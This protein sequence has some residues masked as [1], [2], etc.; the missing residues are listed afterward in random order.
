[1]RPENGVI[2]ESPETHNLVLH[3]ILYV[4]LPLWGFWGFVDWCCHRKT[5][6][7]STSGLHESLLHVTMGIQVGIPIIL[8]IVFEMNVLVM[9]CCF[10]S[11][12]C[13]ELV[14][15]Y[16]VHYT[17]PHREISI[18][19]VH[20]HNYLATVPFYMVALVVV[21]N[22]DVFLAMVTFDWAGQMELAR[23]VV[24]VGGTAYLPS[25]LLFMSVVCY[26]P[27]IEEILRCYRA[28]RREAA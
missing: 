7:E 3:L 19:E 28:S 18:W 24:P 12:I 2:M 27:Y 16:D 13:H 1:M 22:F 14:A 20:A 25:Y 15:H 9:L 17:T 4:M 6:I 11:L 21:R 23:R 26:F 8:S 10:L 5:K